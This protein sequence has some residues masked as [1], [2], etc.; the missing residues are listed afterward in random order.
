[1]KHRPLKTGSS[2]TIT[3]GLTESARA[4]R[5]PLTLTSTQLMRIFTEE[6]VRWQEP[7]FVE[8]IDQ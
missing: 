4:N 3:F 6:L 8:I 1:M 2:A 7:D 5:I